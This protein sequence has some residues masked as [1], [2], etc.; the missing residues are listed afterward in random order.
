MMRDRLVLRGLALLAT[1]T[2]A[3][4][5]AAAWEQKG[6]AIINR[7]AIEAAASKLPEFMNASREQLIYNG[8]EPDRWRREGQTPMTIGFAPDH[9]FDSERWGSIASI[10]PDRYSFMEKLD[11]RKIGLARVGYLPYAIVE[12]YGRLVNAFRY[13]RDPRN[14]KDQAS[15]SANAVY[16][17]G[18]LGH[19]VADGCQPM[20]V[21]IHFNGWTDG[22]PNPKNFTTDRK[23]H[24]RY[25]T[26]Y[27]NAALDTARVRSHAR[28]PERLPNVWGSIQQ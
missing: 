11:A 27:V 21:S 6:H 13:L 26:L 8:F 23:L 17:A 5:S 2:L 25:E 18:V 19:Y 28:A 10:E 1:M 20:H 3:P 12:N 16:V 4:L 7:L 14:A 24:S 22:V 9:F 15:L